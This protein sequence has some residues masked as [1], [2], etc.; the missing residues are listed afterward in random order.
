[1][2]YLRHLKKHIYNLMV[3]IKNEFVKKVWANL[4][5]KRLIIRAVLATAFVLA[6]LVIYISYL[7]LGS[8]DDTG[9]WAAIAAG[10]AVIAAASSSWASIKSMEMQEDDRRPYPYP[11]IDIR[12]RPHLIQFRVANAGGTTAHNIRIIWEKPLFG[13]DGKPVHFTDNENAP[14]ITVLL[15]KESVSILVDGATQFFSKNKDANYSGEIEFSDSTMNTIR[16]PFF[17]SVE[18]YRKS[19]IYQTAE[20]ETHDSLR[21]IPGKISELTTEVRK[22][23]EK[24]PSKDVPL[25]YVLGA[26]QSD[27]DK[28]NREGDTLPRPR[29]NDDTEKSS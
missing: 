16:Y 29:E 3:R 20:D 18:A 7:A 22:L 2:A 8:P 23:Q 1:M 14:D 11:S 17:V 15:P 25:S 6:L 13:R 9:N 4:M 10:L 5:L 21:K 24:I 12:S 27:L 19:M 28:F 26:I